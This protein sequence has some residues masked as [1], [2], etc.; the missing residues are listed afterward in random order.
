[1]D[2]GF[3][4][5]PLEAMSV[6]TSVVCS[7]LPVLHEV[8]GGAATFADTSDAASLAA[9]VRGAAANRTPSSAAAAGAAQA[10]S[11]QWDRA[12][13]AQVNWY[14]DATQAHR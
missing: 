10:A 12:A 3:G 8:L 11:Y 2:E 6:G 1:M 7:D 9:A 4:F 5:P 14:R 13:A